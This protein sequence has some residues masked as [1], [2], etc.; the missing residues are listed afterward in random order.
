MA[1]DEG[2]I[3]SSALLTLLGESIADL[4]LYGADFDDF[5]PLLLVLA[6]DKS[7]LLETQLFKFSHIFNNFGLLLIDL[8]VTLREHFFHY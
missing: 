5:I 4:A 1:Q 2:D 7:K 8:I 6:L 3:V